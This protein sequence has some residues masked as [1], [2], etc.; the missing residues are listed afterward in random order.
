MSSV[1]LFDGVRFELRRNLSHFTKRSKIKPV[2]CNFK[3][4]QPEVQGIGSETNRIDENHY[5]KENNF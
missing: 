1:G 4:N 3:L 2:L 5:S